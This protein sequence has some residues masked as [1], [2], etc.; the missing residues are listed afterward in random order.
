MSKLPSPR[1][2]A[3]SLDIKIQRHQLNSKDM[4]EF[5]EYVQKQKKTNPDVKV[6][7]KDYVQEKFYAGV[8]NI[9]VVPDFSGVTIGKTIDYDVE[10]LKNAFELD[11]AAGMSEPDKENEPDF[12]RNMKGV[13]D[14]K[15]EQNLDLSGVDFIGCR[16][17]AAR[18][19]SCN[20]TG[21]DARD[22]DLSGV[23]LK[24]CVAK[25]M[26]FR[27]SDISGLQFEELDLGGVLWDN[28][29]ALKPI[30]ESSL[31]EYRNNNVYTDMHFSTAESM[32][33][34]Y[35]DENERL[36]KAAEEKFYEKRNEALKEKQEALESAE[37]RVNEAYNKVS[38]W[39][40]AAGGDEYNAYTDIRD[41]ET[42]KINKL[43]QEISELN[44]QEFDDKER[45][46]V[47]YVVHPN[48]V[49]NLILVSDSVKNQYDPAYRRGSSKEQQ[50]EKNQYVRF[51]REDAE[52]YLK[53]CESNPD[54]SIN[55]FAKGLIES[56]GIKEIPGAKIVADFSVYIDK[57]QENYKYAGVT[58]D[59]SGLDFSNRD[60]RGA[61]FVGTNLQDCKFNNA[62]LDN[63]TLEGA[64][65]SRADFTGV[66]AKDTNLQAAKI[67]S[68]IIENADFSR[69]YMPHARVH[70]LERDEIS[71]VV[72]TP[73]KLHVAKS[74]FD[75]ANLSNANLDG[76]KIENST[77]D[78]AELS[79]VSLANADIQR[80]KMRHA[81]LERAILNNCQMIET[82]LSGSILREAEAKKA[83]FKETVLEQV[84]A[85]SMNLSESEIGE[86]CKLS[87]AN[88][89]KAIMQRVK[90]DRVN[91]VDVNMKEANLQYAQLKG[92]IVNEVD[93]SFANLEG[94]V[95]D[96]I[97]AS[98]VNMT[99]ADLSGIS[100]R[101]AEFKDA[102]LEAIKAHRA[103]LSEAVLE[104][105]KL[106]GA[107]MH[108]AILEKVNLK[109]ADLRN[110]E[111]ERANLEKANVDNAKVNDG[112]DINHA[113]ATGIS[114]E[115]EHEAEDGTKIKMKP[116]VKIEQDNQAHA[117]KN[118]SALGKFAAQVAGVVGSGVKK[119]GEFINQP[120]STKWGRIIGATIGVVVAAAIITSTVLTA[121]LSIPVMAAVAAGTV[122]A[123]GGAGA[124]AGHF[125]AKHSGLST[126]VGAGAGFGV[127]GP[128]GA[129]IGAVAMGAVNSVSKQIFGTTI[130]RAVGGTFEKVGESGQKHA[131]NVEKQREREM[132]QQKSNDLYKPPTKEASKD[133]KIDRTQEAINR[134]VA[135]SRS[136]DVDMSKGESEL[137]AKQKAT[138]PKEKT[139]SSQLEIEAK[140]VGKTMEEKISNGKDKTPIVKPKTPTK[141]NVMQK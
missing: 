17:E 112:T 63:A 19:E 33:H 84:D 35:R 54:L 103:D 95:A 36:E 30:S 15:R 87:G 18:F 77:F 57:S 16:M 3:E 82:D 61:C 1:Q 120:L 37:R 98:G 108:D 119:V 133:Q 137:S 55:E 62:K 93:L 7:L 51:K 13:V 52:N 104:G 60:L 26:D 34:R 32:L 99:G 27:G 10:S 107:K 106:R 39:Q 114:G 130:D 38:Y 66:S 100:A 9:V 141:E 23:V 85:R 140:K 56:K 124:V 86:L 40:R 115:F 111:L 134:E 28:N 117:S 70:D 5:V 50:Q 97:K 31:L 74:K 110:A 44:Q 79:G 67:Q 76:A 4:E 125:A 73:G 64:D 116:E 58:T 88:L 14:A 69:A 113:K 41:I 53:A 101:G 127:I 80:C 105:A 94:A 29:V 43:K 135:Q 126:F 6:S 83:T 42:P 72:Q 91:F 121:G 71:E 68:A 128:V 49:D 24:D 92:A 139:V 22:A 11:K 118:R 138:S 45:K 8:E 20:L 47:K 102:Q 109:K 81:N 89:E 59:L 48:V 122:L 131:E 21:V 132:A 90:A 46:Q 2:I 65:A 25:E 129:A 136:K 123:C 78:Y 12:L 96:G 75:F